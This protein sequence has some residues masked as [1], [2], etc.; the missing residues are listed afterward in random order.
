M[1]GRATSTKLTGTR[2]SPTIRSPGIVARASC[3]VETPPS[4]EF[5]I[6]II[7]ASLRPWMT[8]PS[9]SPTLNTGRQSW[10]RASGTWARAAS[11]NVP[12]GPR[13]LYVRR[14]GISGSLV[15]RFSLSPRHPPAVRACP[16]ARAHYHPHES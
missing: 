10:P 9:A 14:A 6:A 3:V 11:V 1:P 7:A 4:T 12:A 8:S 15:T 2:Y 13:K 5:S 16:P